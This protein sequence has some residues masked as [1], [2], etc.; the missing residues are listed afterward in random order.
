MFTGFEFL[1]KYFEKPNFLLLHCIKQCQLFQQALQTIP[2]YVPGQDPFM[3]MDEVIFEAH[4][5]FHGS[6]YKHWKNQ[7]QAH[8]ASNEHLEPL[9]LANYFIHSVLLVNA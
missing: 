9:S 3:Q 6:V 1:A 2:A 5:E 4:F 8:M 7:R